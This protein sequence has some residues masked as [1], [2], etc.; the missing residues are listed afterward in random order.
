VVAACADNLLRVDHL[1]VRRQTPVEHDCG[2]AVKGSRILILGLAYK[3]NVDDERESPSYRLLEKL[4]Q[5]GAIVAYRDP[6]VPVIRPTREHPRW[7][8]TK[9]V[10]VDQA[11]DLLIRS[12]RNRDCPRLCKLS[13]T[14]RLGAVHCRYEKRYGCRSGR[15]HK[16]LEGLTAT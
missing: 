4:K 5:R 1:Q 10:P 8:G 14:C 7:A 15:A 13:R 2:K 16:G 9:S 3:P 12:S 11:N 6:H